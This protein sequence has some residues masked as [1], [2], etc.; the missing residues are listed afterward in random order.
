[1][2]FTDEGTENV[3]AD[4]GKRKACVGILIMIIIIIVSSKKAGSIL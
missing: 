2:A 1:M 3:E 4:V